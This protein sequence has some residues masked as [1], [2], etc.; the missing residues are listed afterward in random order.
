MDLR[1]YHYG[2]R[3]VFEGTRPVYG[4]GSGLGWPM[5]YR[6]PPLFL[7]LFAPLAMVPLGWAAA[8]WVVGKVAV[9]VVL[10]RALERRLKP[11]T[12]FGP[13]NVVAGFSR[14]YAVIS[15]LLITPYLVE[16]FRYGN[17]QF[18][19][20][21]LTAASLLLVREKPVLSAA[22]LALG[23]SIKVWPLFF[24]PYLAARRDW[25]VAGY[26]LGFVVVL[27]ILP[28]LYFGF[29]G[30]I[31]LLGQWFSQE[32][33]TQLGNSEIW[34]P[35][36][37]LRGLLTRYLTVVDYSL[38]PDSNYPQVHIAALD[39]GLVRWIWLIV[40]AAA[41]AAF[42]VASGRRRNTNGWFDHGLAFCLLPLLEPFTQ[43][44]ALAVLL[45]PAL[46]A[47]FLIAKPG[48][49][50][51]IYLSIVLALVQP[52]A[53]GSATQRLLQVLGLDFA[54]TLFLT[55][56]IAYASHE[57]AEDS[58]LSHKTEKT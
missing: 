10:L 54:V 46:I 39:P 7:L 16:E 25:K 31:D 30:N 27:A 13:Q 42:L 57:F 55:A 45:W 37:A 8:I 33:Q 19:V 6:Y 26:T 12:T 9:L 44:Y 53:P 51:L 41:Y 23:I 4:P 43:K 32:S 1:V 24:V 22:S 17:A 11:A 21:A 14:R 56:A 49:R 48:L 28:S 52:L 35:N 38:V 18:F 20:V 47:G 34:F 2:A 36:Q 29:F 50:I 3:G 58:F 5:H 15:F 40:A